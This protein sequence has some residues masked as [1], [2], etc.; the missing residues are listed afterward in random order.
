MK[1]TIQQLVAGTLTPVDVTGDKIV[2]Q[3]DGSG[4]ANVKVYA[5]GRLVRWRSMRLVET[6]DVEVDDGA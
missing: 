5:A 3:L 1:A 4:L 6:I 2:T